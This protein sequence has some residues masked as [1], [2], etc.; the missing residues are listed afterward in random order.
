M[1]QHNP[2]YTLGRGANDTHLTFLQPGDA[3]REALARRGSAQLSLDRSILVDRTSDV[4][5]VILNLSSRAT[6]VMAPNG[7]PI[8]RIDRGG[9]VTFHG[10]GQL[11]IYPLLY[12]QHAPLKPDLHW[13]LR[14]VEQVVID[15]LADYGIEGVRDEINTGVWVGPDKIAAVGVSASRWITTHGLALNVSTDLTYFDASILRPCGIE[16][17]GVTSLERVLKQCH[18]ES[19]LVPKMVEVA[20][21]ALHHLQ[22][23]FDIEIEDAVVPIR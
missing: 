15:T 6:A 20:Q 17:R 11:V 4:E 22:I 19:V 13:Y 12:L 5:T 9:E 8:Y 10:P 16:G 1:L 14:N 2:F 21:H 23:V 7:V 3:R 18:G